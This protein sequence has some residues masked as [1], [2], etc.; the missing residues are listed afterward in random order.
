MPSEKRI[1][2]LST[3]NVNLEF[4]E[5]AMTA[6]GGFG[7]IAKFMEKIHFREHLERAVPFTEISP[8][9]TGVFAKII[10]YGLTVMAGGRRFSHTMFLGDSL[11]V[12]ETE[13]G[14]DRIPK[15]ITAVTRF[16]A[17]FK[18][19]HKVE[20]FSDAVW[21][22]TMNNLFR[23]LKIKEDYLT[24]DS[25]V[26]T[27]YGDQEAVEIGYNPKKK[28]RGSHHPILAFLNRS[29][30]IVN[31]WN[32]PGSTSSGN[33]IIEF[34]KQTLERIGTSVNILG[35]LADSGFYNEI[36]LDFLEE[37]KIEYV[38]AGV[39]YS[40]LQKA[41]AKVEN[42]T[43]VDDGI[44]VA[45][46]QFQHQSW[47]K[48]RRYVLIRQQITTKTKPPG[49]Q[50]KLFEDDEAVSQFRYG[51]YVTTSSMVSVEVWRKY[52]L[53]AADEGIIKELKY[54]FSL[55]GFCLEKFYPTESAMILRA[56]F[57]NLMEVFCQ[58]FLESKEAKISFNTFRMKYLLIPSVLG[59][60]GKNIILRMAVRAQD[61]RAKIRK[62]IERIEQLLVPGPNALHLADVL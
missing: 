19:Q 62:I 51:V 40:T 41:I 30:F 50:L 27:R 15:S 8:N 52:R 37:K 28:G 57:Y 26:L 22:F 31:L 45:E 42:W 11:E 23:L 54:D 53:R 46:M 44:E 18:S 33:G 48:P 25:T 7:L 3:N 29:R 5:K 38:I 56:L 12:Y 55:E 32:R 36:F 21:S 4:T 61:M 39:L 34:A 14:L 59:R 17:K 49:R 13:F 58:C 20:I 60:D 2:L 47:E 24:F 6:Y 1:K 43:R 9:S 10:R 16:F 35:V